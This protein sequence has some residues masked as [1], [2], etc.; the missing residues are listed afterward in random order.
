VIGKKGEE[1]SRLTF[2]ICNYENWGLNAQNVRKNDITTVKS[3]LF[4]DVTLYNLIKI[5]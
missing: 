3:T 2:K 4:L 1:R 5:Y